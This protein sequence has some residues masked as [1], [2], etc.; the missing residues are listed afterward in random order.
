MGFVMP[1]FAR[2]LLRSSHVGAIMASQRD[3]SQQTLSSEVGNSDSDSLRNVDIEVK[4][5]SSPSPSLFSVSDP[6]P[7]RNYDEFEFLDPESN[8]SL[9]GITASPITTR[10]KLLLAIHLRN[11]RGVL[12]ILEDA[13]DAAELVHEVEKPSGDP[14]SWPI[15]PLSLALLE[16]DAPIVK[17]ILQH[18]KAGSCGSAIKY[19][20]EQLLPA[21]QERMLEQEPKDE[22]STGSWN[23]SPEFDGRFE[24]PLLELHNCAVRFM[25]SDPASAEKKNLRDHFLARS[26]PPHSFLRYRKRWFGHRN[27]GDP[28]SLA[29][30]SLL[31]SSGDVNELFQLLRDASLDLH[32]AHFCDIG[33][34]VWFWAAQQGHIGILSA[35]LEDGFPIN[36]RATATRFASGPC[37]PFSATWRGGYF[38]AAPPDTT[39][40]W[41]S[42]WKSA[43][44]SADFLLSR[45]ALLNVVLVKTEKSFTEKLSRIAYAYLE[46]QTDHYLRSNTKSPKRSQARITSPLPEDNEDMAALFHDDK[47][48]RLAI[49]GGSSSDR[50]LEELQAL[51]IGMSYLPLKRH[52]HDPNVV[53]MEIVRYTAILSLLLQAGAEPNIMSSFEPIVKRYTYQD[54][55]FNTSKTPPIIWDFA[56][57]GNKPAIENLIKYGA[58]I[59]GRFDSNRTLLHYVVESEDEELM[60]YALDQGIAVNQKDSTGLA[61]IHYCILQRKL[62]SLKFVLQNGVMPDEPSAQGM[63]PLLMATSL[64]DLESTNML[65]MHGADPSCG[66]GEEIVYLAEPDLGN[67]SLAAVF[68]AGT[69]LLAALRSKDCQIDIVSSLLRSGADAQQ[70]GIIAMRRGRRSVVYS[71][72][73]IPG[74]YMVSSS[75]RH[76]F[77]NDRVN[78]IDFDPL[79]TSDQSS[80]L[81]HPAWGWDAHKYTPLQYATLFFT[82]ITIDSFAM[83]TWVT[84]LKMLLEHAGRSDKPISR[85]CLDNCLRSLCA[86]DLACD[87]SD[88]GFDR[89]V[90]RWSAPLDAIDLLLKYG[91]SPMVRGAQGLSL[92]HTI[93]S[94]ECSIETES[95]R[96][97]TMI[98]RLVKLGADVNTRD[99]YGRTPLHYSVVLCPSVITTLV[100]Y[101]ADSR[102]S[103]RAGRTPIL[104]ACG[105]KLLSA[106]SFRPESLRILLDLHDGSF[107]FWNEV[108]LAACNRAGQEP[109][110]RSRKSDVDVQKLI[111][112]L[113]EMDKESR[114][115]V[116]SDSDK[117]GNTALHLAADREFVEPLKGLCSP[118]L[119][120]QAFAMQNAQGETPLIKVCQYGGS[121]RVRIVLQAIRDSRLLPWVMHPNPRK[122]FESKPWDDRQGN[123]TE[124]VTGES[125]KKTVAT[126]GQDDK[127]PEQPSPVHTQGL[128]QCLNTQDSYGW[129]ALHYAARRGDQEVVQLLV[130]EPLLDV[131]LSHGCCVPSPLDLAYKSE[132]G[133]CVRLIRDAIA[134]RRHE[135][136]QQRPEPEGKLP[137]LRSKAH[138]ASTLTYVGMLVDVMQRWHVRIF[139]GMLSLLWVLARLMYVEN[140]SSS[141]SALEN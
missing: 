10:Q 37:F 66:F 118:P 134:A 86:I 58:D 53:K 68:R 114:M 38:E 7:R 60:Q 25:W 51:S 108:L 84:L 111:E 113:V 91:A 76:E 5:F 90:R 55:V 117:N 47:W 122:M 40:L 78:Q 23:L 89:G 116:L 133:V 22:Y 19:E 88:T 103:D 127:I 21:A 69:P 119:P 11:L 131:G 34:T 63:S 141:V 124:I 105:G 42:V 8:D 75:R 87:W 26:L 30:R 44:N 136:D 14:A 97:I 128:S 99:A 12:D 59:H 43:R 72:N 115:H 80:L 129:T 125:I 123:Y 29:L 28:T 33:R 101:G 100:K 138:S 130:S 81:W 112:D 16:G 85:M 15:T 95:Q 140:S 2:E 57:I 135:L 48:L 17:A 74:S 93:C 41:N 120:W 102:L 64:S 6:N 36:F 13:H 49:F 77:Y 52:L 9:T 139:I 70:P 46:G 56:R 3:D 20:V 79:W 27:P 106:Y 96:L 98:H 132:D 137:S 109:R 83:E 32:N 121:E 67:H 4:I 18:S 39:A 1:N 82:N 61:A 126:A 50:S 110:S 71:D 94:S 54:V 73:P 62:L 45:G 107:V 65:L 31:F 104:Y 24:L 35:F 92:V